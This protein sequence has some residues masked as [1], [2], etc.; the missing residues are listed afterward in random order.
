MK[1]VYSG[2]PKI[3]FYM[4]ITITVALSIFFWLWTHTDRPETPRELWN[5]EESQ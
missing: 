2:N 1:L 3:V 4:L 5:L